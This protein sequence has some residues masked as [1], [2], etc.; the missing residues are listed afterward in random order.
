M[1]G[2]Q[3]LQNKEHVRAHEENGYL[4]GKGMGELHADSLTL[5]FQQCEEMHVLFCHGN[6]RINVV[7][8]KGCFI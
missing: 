1:P 5:D 2:S 8:G 7:R 3:Y 6:P 4:Q